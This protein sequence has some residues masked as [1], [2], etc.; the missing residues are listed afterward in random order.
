MRVQTC[1]RPPKDFPQPL[2]LLENCMS[3]FLMTA[4]LLTAPA[5]AGEK[6][7][8]DRI[9]NSSIKFLD[10]AV[11]LP[12][13]K[14][15][16]AW[17]IP[18]FG[19]Q[20]AGYAQL[21]GVMAGLNKAA[22]ASL[23]EKRG[24]RDEGPVD[25][26][27]PGDGDIPAIFIRDFEKMEIVWNKTV[28]GDATF[29]VRSPAGARLT[30]GCDYRVE[31]YMNGD[32]SGLT[33]PE[34]V[35]HSK[36]KLEEAVQ[37]INKN[38]AAGIN[39][40]WQLVRCA[41]EQPLLHG[42]MGLALTSLRMRGDMTSALASDYAETSEARAAYAALS[43]DILAWRKAGASAEPGAALAGIRPATTGA[44]A[45]PVR[46]D[47]TRANWEMLFVTAEVSKGAVK[48]LAKQLPGRD[49]KLAQKA[50]E[51][52]TEMV[53]NAVSSK[54]TENLPADH[55]FDSACDLVVW[56]DAAYVHRPDYQAIVATAKQ[57]YPEVGTDYRQ[58]LMEK[59]RE[60]G[61][62]GLEAP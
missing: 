45:S 23:L 21:D 4:L 7:L 53:G 44:F 6:A 33:N 40:G 51:V 5:H 35:S 10:G 49:G 2:R 61:E 11:P 17:G 25:L 54:I 57:A 43:D 27:D 28:A 38:Q 37:R 39:S 42:E 55:Y 3:A 29:V 31:L 32:K 34:G 41:D 22:E 1:C 18:D 15:V 62:A 50:T 9:G 20:M 56:M 48:T 26:A 30:L 58:C 24:G 36:D 12:P 19:A 47:G 46:A 59:A 16:V 8:E 14:V 52:G 60:R 13:A